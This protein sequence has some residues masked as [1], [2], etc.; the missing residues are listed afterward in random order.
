MRKGNRYYYLVLIW[1]R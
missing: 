1:E